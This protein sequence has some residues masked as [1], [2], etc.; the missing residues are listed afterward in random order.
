MSIRYLFM[1]AAGLAFA[2]NA[3]AEDG[4]ALAKKNHCT[5]CHGI[6][7]RNIGPAFKEVAAEYKDDKN[8]Q[9]TLEMKVRNGG[10]G[11]WGK[12]PMPPTRKWASEEDIKSIVQWVLSL[13]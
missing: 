1:L 11:V 12:L 8:A 4:E 13:K 3:L 7:K 10:S 2:G 9:A 5:A 6:D